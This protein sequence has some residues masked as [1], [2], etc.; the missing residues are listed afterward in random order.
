MYECMENERETWNTQLKYNKRQDILVF[1][2]NI[3]WLI[4]PYM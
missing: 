2:V 3:W 1:Q 4:A